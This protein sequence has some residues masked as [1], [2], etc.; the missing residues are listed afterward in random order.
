MLPI[1]FKLVERT[2]RRDFYIFIHI[3]HLEIW[4]VCLPSINPMKGVHLVD[5][6]IQE[7]ILNK[8]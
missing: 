2:V 6:F 1:P 5:K 4:R 8:S 3:H 7:R